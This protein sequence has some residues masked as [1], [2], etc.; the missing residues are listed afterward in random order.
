MAEF[1][2]IYAGAAPP[3]KVVLVFLCAAACLAVGL[4]IL[5]KFRTGP[6]ATTLSGLRAGAP[7]LGLL[8][9]AMNSFHMARTVQKLPFDVTA[10]QLAPGVLEVATLVGLG[11]VVGLVA[12]AALMSISAFRRP[13]ASGAKPR[14]HA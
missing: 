7:T 10:K 3:Q 4:A 14:S 9:G 11:A 6:W 12:Q 5:A 2:S 8:V 1:S 13:L